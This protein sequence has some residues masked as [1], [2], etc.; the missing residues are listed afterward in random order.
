M[1][2][3]TDLGTLRKEGLSHLFNGKPWISVGLGTCGIG[4][5]RRGFPSPAR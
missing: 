5:E 2:T 4:N 1:K 3:Q